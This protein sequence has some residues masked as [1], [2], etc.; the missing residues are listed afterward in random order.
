MNDIKF[1]SEVRGI[2]IKNTVWYYQEFDDY[3]E[4]RMYA[5]TYGRKEN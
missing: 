4:M 3:V 5:K 1:I 2:C